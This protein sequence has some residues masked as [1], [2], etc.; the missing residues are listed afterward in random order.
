MA[1]VSGGGRPITD[2]NVEERGHGAWLDSPVTIVDWTIVAFAVVMAYWGFR[3]GLIVGV[4][5]LAGFA[6]G[7]FAGSRLA[8]QLLP[9]G[10][11]SPY[12][13]ALALTGAVLVGGMVAVLLEEL[14]VMT[15]GRLIRGQGAQVLDGAGGAV[16]VA[17]IGLGLAW[18]LGA[19]ALNA[20]GASD[21]RREAQRSVILRELNQILPPTAV[22]NALNRVDPRLE[23]EGPQ[24]E[25]S[26]PDRRIARDPEVRAAGE[27]VVKVIGTA[28]GL[29]VSGSG[30]VAEP[31][32]VVTNAHVV[33][34][35]DDTAVE[36]PDGERLDANPIHYEPRNDL[37]VLRVD[38]VDG[39]PLAFGEPV[40][41]TSGAVLGYPEDGPFE[42][43]AARLGETQ[44]AVSQDSYGRGPIE[45]QLTVLR[46]AVREG[47]SG[48]PMVDGAGRVLTTVFA[49]TVG[50]KRGGYGVP[51]S[52]V[53][54]ALARAGDEVGTGPCT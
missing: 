4:F 14:A 43:T 54:R 53:Q 26:A 39:E 41:R 24:P 6:A 28:C 29:G 42:V 17:A 40:V 3:Q 31:G 25:V 1:S 7:A 49:A 27:S 44:T 19:V 50:E 11:E 33:A 38:G 46:G 5:S 8:P 2:E 32:L 36:E 13:P 37:A 20:P 16:L 23:L 22:L 15:R 52:I 10:S 18:L 9:D 21:V 35:Q 34:G 48:G 45:R 12:A 51:N 47:N 30:W